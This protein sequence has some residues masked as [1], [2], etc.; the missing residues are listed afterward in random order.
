M[1][2]ANELDMDTQTLT[3]SEPLCAAEEKEDSLSVSDS[4]C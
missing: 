2:A 1:L 4:E 3:D